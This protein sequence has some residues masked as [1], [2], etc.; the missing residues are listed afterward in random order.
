MA[1]EYHPE[2]NRDFRR[3][4][5]GSIPQTALAGGSLLYMSQLGNIGG[6]D[7]GL[8]SA[9]ARDSIRRDPRLKINNPNLK[10]MFGAMGINMPFDIDPLGSSY[11]PRTHTVNAPRSNYGILAH[12]LGHAEQYKNPLYKKTLGRVSGIGRR[13]AP[14][15]VLAPILTDNEQEAKRNSLIASGLQVPTLIEEIDASRRGSNIL[16]KTIAKREKELKSVPYA[17][18][19]NQAKK[20]GKIAQALTRLRPFAGVPT[21]A[22]AAAAPYLLYKYMKGRGLYEGEY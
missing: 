12:E 8:A 17:N 21:Y 19:A 20:G 5:E 11:Q 1:T 16:G 10:N 18:S 9:L 6:N 2:G 14:F 7:K 13:V 15:G 4:I 3:W 22:L